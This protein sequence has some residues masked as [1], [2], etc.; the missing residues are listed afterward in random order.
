MSG[1]NCFSE[2]SREEKGD[3]T[4]SVGHVFV[5]KIFPVYLCIV[6]SLLPP[7]RGSGT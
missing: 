1:L 4:L 2:V 6:G 5:F 3:L 7:L